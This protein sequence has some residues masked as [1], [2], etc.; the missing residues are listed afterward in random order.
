MAARRGAGRKPDAHAMLLQPLSSH[1]APRMPRGHFRASC[2]ARPSCPRTQ[3]PAP[4]PP[5]SKGA[6]GRHATGTARRP[7]STPAG[8]R[9]V[10]GGQRF[11]AQRLPPAPAVGASDGRGPNGGA[12]MAATP[13]KSARLLP[14]GGRRVGNIRM[15][16]PGPPRQTS[17][18]S[19]AASA[20]RSRICGSRC[21]GLVHLGVRGQ[22]PGSLSLSSHSND[23]E[24]IQLN[25]LHVVANRPVRPSTCECASG[26]PAQPFHPCANWL[27]RASVQHG[28]DTAC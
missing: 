18:R 12:S 6:R 26:A 8:P 28:D 27:Q 19:T 1:L 24:I 2:D 4:L 20:S 17:C 9:I 10:G 22:R 23:A 21:G 3:A 7:R 14:R 16:K 25:A 15:S 13:A 5:S 11:P